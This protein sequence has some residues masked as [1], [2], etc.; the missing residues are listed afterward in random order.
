MKC[1]CLFSYDM[2]GCKLIFIKLSE[3]IL[4][5]DEFDTFSSTFYQHQVILAR[6]NDVTYIFINRSSAL[7]LVKI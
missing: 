3:Y 6:K 1:E 2:W 4:A 7:L 5:F